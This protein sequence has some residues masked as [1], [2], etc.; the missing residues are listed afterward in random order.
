MARTIDEIQQ[1]IIADVQ[2]QPELAQATSTSKRAIWRL[3]TY[4]VAVAINLLEQLMDVF[5]AETEKLVA[6]TPPQTSQWLQD[7]VFK[8]QY[9]TTNP[10]I[11]QLI[12]FAPQYPVVNSALRIVTRCSVKSSTAG[13]VIVKTAKHEPPTPLSALEL[14]SL[15]SYVSLIGVTGINYGVISSDSDKLYIEADIYYNGS[16]SA[17]IQSY[18]INTIQNYLSTLPFDG[19]F[20]V[21]DLEVAIRNTEG[22][23]DC[24]LKNVIARAD[25][26]TLANGTYLVINNQFVGRVWPTV[27]GYMVTETTSGS[28][29]N[30]TLTFI[31]E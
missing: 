28:T 23:N 26:T 12:D 19:S 15:Q 24:V 2:G 27:A 31:A 7:R 11:I 14:A 4:V 6:V 17:I 29:I 22:V 3:W 18:V 10:Q 16:Y 13:S 30:D 9:D 25:G 20:K 1:A 8:F 21:N 5:R